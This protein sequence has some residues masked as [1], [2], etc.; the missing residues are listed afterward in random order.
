MQT[1]EIFSI[2]GIEETR[3]EKA[4]KAAYREKLAVTNPE[5]NPEG[6]KRL[7][8]AYEEALALE[9]QPE[10]KPQEED[11]TETGQW[12]AQAAGLYGTLN[13][14]QD[15]E[16]WK[17]LFTQDIYL[18]LDGEEECQRKLLIFLMQHYRL[19]TAVWKLLEEKLEI[20]RNQSRLKEQFPAEFID[21]LVSRVTR[22]E[23]VE[24]SQFDG[25]QDGDY[26]AFLQCYD[27][28]WRALQEQKLEYAAQLLEESGHM[29]IWHPCMEV[30]RAHYYQACGRQEEAHDCL[31]ALQER[32]P[33]DELVEFN[34]AQLLWDQGQ[35]AEAARC[36]EG[37][38]ERN[39]KHY[40][41]NMRLAKWYHDQGDDH[42]AKKCAEEVLALGYDDDFHQLL[43]EINAGLEKELEEKI[44]QDSRPEDILDIGW[45]YLQDER[46]SVGIRRVKE[47][48]DRVPD[49][50]MEEYLGLMTKL[51]REAAEY[52]KS[53]EYAKRWRQA[54]EKRIPTQEGETLEKDKDRLRQSHAICMQCYRILGYLDKSYYELALEEADAMEAVNPHDIGV[55][56]ERAQTYMEMEEYEKCLELVGRLV[57]EYRVYAALATSL[58]AYRRQWDATGVIQ[59]GRQLI[60]Y[61]PDY[62]KSYVDMAKVYLD[63]KYTK[64]LEELLEEA[65]KK[66]IENAYL[67]AYAYQKD[68]KTNA[69]K[70]QKRVEEFRN[71]FLDHVENGDLS[72]YEPGLA[73]LK[74]LLYQ[75]PGAYLLVERGIF[76][77][78]AHH[79]KEAIRDYEQVLAYVPQQ[80][81]ALNGMSQVHKH[82]GDYEQ[83]I[84][85]LRKAILFDTE[86]DL[87]PGACM[88]IADLYLRLGDYEKALE[89]LEQYVKY[90]DSKKLNTSVYRLGKIATGYIR[91]GK[92]DMA[93]KIL[94][95]AYAKDPVGLYD[96]LADMY[97]VTGQH[98][99]ARN[100]LRQWALRLNID[101]SV[102]GKLLGKMKKGN[103]GYSDYYVSLGWTELIFGD[104]AKAVRAFVHALDYHTDPSK[105]EG[106]LCDAVF[107]C[108]LCG[109]DK[110]GR[111]YA[112]K[113]QDWLR[114][115][116][117]ARRNAYYEQEKGHLE[118][119]IL[120][121]YYTEPEEKLQ[122]L[123]D[124][125]SKCECCNFCTYAI[126]KEM[127]GVRI[128]LML[129]RGQTDEARERLFHNLKIQPQDEYM[130]AIRHMRFEE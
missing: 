126:C 46:F 120:A 101:E 128:L 41:A 89:Y 79:Y 83:A 61:F 43:K 130:L 117:F 93:A 4:I 96:K 36:F 110:L 19:S 129:R 97:Q 5:D 127:E 50:R 18:S 119:E 7:R 25:P 116:Q 66:G 105:A 11:T 20:C 52:E 27:N 90:A 78:A 54:L 88:D 8:Q 13:G 59:T 12:V 2:L 115:E 31:K 82:Q 122:E 6:F 72:F 62:V 65:K 15:L 3:E 107:A 71:I 55:L 70:I 39:D 33:G 87:Q 38:K 1:T 114:Q 44:E 42:R 113:L 92:Y 102:L 108:I 76:H 22:G 64:E 26:D 16:G 84:I 95:S 80:I 35:K 17:E 63:L 23:D 74:E 51:C 100:V 103:A 45:C 104:K 123:L 32:F 73:Q 56:M 121:A 94:E 124:R 58:E 60:Q 109:E 57:Q 48:E 28:C 68:H 98:Q 106:V 111:K 24:F 77:K 40:T 10:T 49:G 14:R 34:L 85:C 30:C 112:S 75:S 9:R 37:I 69:T 81:Y 86:G 99:E 53:I 118:M 21:F 47:I 67:E 29:G 125:E 91:N